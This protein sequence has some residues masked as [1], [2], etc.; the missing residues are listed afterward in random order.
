MDLDGR[1]ERMLGVSAF[2]FSIDWLPDGTLLV[3]GGGQVRRRQADGPLAPYVDLAPLSSH[4]WNEMVVDSSGRAWV[5]SIGFDLMGGGKPAPGS[6]AC[7]DPGG[8]ARIVAGDLAFP[9]GMAV[10]P[11]GRT[12]I[13]AESYAGRLTAFEISASGNLANRRVWAAVEGSAPDGICLDAEGAAWYADV[14]NRCCVRVGEGGEVRDR[15]TVDRGCFACMP[16]GPGGR[17]LFILAAEWKGTG[18]VGGARTGRVYTVEGPAPHA[19][20]P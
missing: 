6:V 3:L 1:A 2:P 19:G 16:G 18:G 5:N 11:D 10:T 14:P 12:L 8:S 9:N 13:V 20:R 15:V 17:T 4:P 7:V